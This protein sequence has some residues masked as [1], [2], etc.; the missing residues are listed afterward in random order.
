MQEN[1]NA[2]RVIGRYFVAFSRLIAFMWADM[3]TRLAKPGDARLM[4]FVFGEA[5]VR[6][7][8]N[9]FFA[10]CEECGEF[11]E[12]ETLVSRA[13]KRQVEAV[14]GR[15][16][17]FAHGDWWV[18]EEGGL[19]MRPIQPIELV[20]VRPGCRTE[21]RTSE[22]LTVDTLDA[23]AEA[24]ESVDVRDVAGM[25][26]ERRKVKV[27]G[28]PLQR[29]GLLEAAVRRDSAVTRPRRTRPGRS[30][31]RLVQR[32][33]RTAPPPNRTRYQVVAAAAGSRSEAGG[34]AAR[35]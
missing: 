29:A 27:K 20:R 10:M 17:A 5:T 18:G 32:S 31:L 11:D 21:A 22:L 35:R 14:S 26:I 4:S 7:I 2:C 15:R 30:Q 6:A 19:G 1:D 16:N 25:P 3:S 23:E 34:P 13:L 9:S 33:A 28:R 12:E 8:T 24:I